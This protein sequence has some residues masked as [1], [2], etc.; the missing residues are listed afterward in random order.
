MA[1]IQ[2]PVRLDPI[3]TTEMEEDEHKYSDRHKK[4]MR[5]IERSNISL[6]DKIWAES[7]GQDDIEQE[8]K[9]WVK[10]AL[11]GEG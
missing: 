4:H 9:R 3:R 6:P 5:R 8:Y 2:V 7:P 10:L 11:T 1:V